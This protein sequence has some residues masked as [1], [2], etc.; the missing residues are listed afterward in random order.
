MNLGSEK[1]VSV[2]TFRKDATPVATPVWCAQDDDALVFW[3]VTDSGKVKRI[4]RDPSVSVAPCDVRGRVT[5][6][7]V[8]GRAEILSAAET[9]R[10]R[11][12][13]R[14]KYG[15]IGRITL[16]GSRIRRGPSGTVAV[17]VT[18]I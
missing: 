3:T 1:Y 15:L 17:R 5:G 14:R 10:V 4:R 18:E 12:L 6:E 11:G 2:T 8:A 13:L 9:E 16:L 7:P